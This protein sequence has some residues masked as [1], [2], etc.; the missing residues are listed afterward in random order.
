MLT[1]ETPLRTS[2]EMPLETPLGTKSEMPLDTPLGRTTETPLGMPLGTPLEAPLGGTSETP[3]AR[4]VRG[5]AP[6]AA[7]VVVVAG[8]GS[9]RPSLDRWWAEVLEAWT[10]RKSWHLSHSL[11]VA[12]PQLAA[13][14]ER[15]H[16]YVVRPAVL[17]RQVV[18][19]GVPGGAA[20]TGLLEE[21]ASLVTAVTAPFHGASAEL[22]R[23]P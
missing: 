10:S 23:S 22:V 7:M 4:A 16:A 14:A 2:S 18:L 21:V 12:A 19:E 11:L 9:G 20:T 3:L 17:A 13:L 15:F 6:T 1:A 8:V 5:E